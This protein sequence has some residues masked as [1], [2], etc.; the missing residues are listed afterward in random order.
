MGAGVQGGAAKGGS[1]GG[2]EGSAPGRQGKHCSG[3][4][5]PP[6]FGRLAQLLPLMIAAT[7]GMSLVVSGHSRSVAGAQLQDRTAFVCLCESQPGH[8][9]HTSETIVRGNSACR[10]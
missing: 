5:H 9:L 2:C 3:H 7:H 6:L 4:L 8:D 10:L 1:A